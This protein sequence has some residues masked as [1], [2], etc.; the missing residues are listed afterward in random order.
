MPHRFRPLCLLLLALVA[1]APLFGQDLAAFEK[2]VTEFTLANGMHFIVLERH[3]APVV[4]FVTWANVGSVDDPKGETGLAHMFEH[5]AIK[6]TTTIGT[7]NWPKEKVALAAEDAA[8]EALEAERRKGLHADAGTVKALQADFLAKQKLA[9]SYVVDN[10]YPR[11]IESN[12]GVGLNAFT[13]EDATVYFYSLP[14]NRAELWFYLESERFLHPVFREFYKERDVVR[15]ERRMRTESNPQGQLIEDVLGA[16]YLA[17]PYKNPAVGWPSDV[18]NLTLREADKFYK[19]HYGPNN[20]TAA[21]VGDVNPEQVKRWATAYFGRLPRGPA[22]QPVITVEPPQDG[23]RRV[24]VDSPTQPILL[25]T[26][27]RPAETDPDRAVFG[28]ISSLLSDGRTSWLYRSLVRD[29]KLALFAGGFANFPGVKY[30]ELFVFYDVPAPGHS[31][32]ENLK[33]MDEQIDRLR[34]QPVDAATLQMVKTKNRAALVR[35]LDN[36]AGLAQELASNSVIFGDWRQLFRSADEIDRVTAADV[37]RV[38]RQYFQPQM[39]T[40]GYLVKPPQP[41]SKTSGTPGE[42]H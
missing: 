22:A 20:L 39:R 24:E 29:K 26:Y 19:A 16:S 18:E 35:Q 15:E 33:A 25:M 6:G 40:I 2:H 10:E 17:H 9:S 4:S 7:T 36:N 14:S 38:A 3:E 11:L 41:P 12:G 21:I 23:E 1:S 13:S 27:H 37:Q 32:E 31:V 34:T 28:V 8:Y 5:M 30:P 42:A